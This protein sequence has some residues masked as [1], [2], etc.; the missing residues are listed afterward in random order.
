MIWVGDMNGG[1]VMVM[2]YGVA[3]WIG[4]AFFMDCNVGH[5]GFWCNCLYHDFQPCRML[6]GCL[7]EHGLNDTG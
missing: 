6:T 5:I 2:G 1:V 3:D 7:H 4:W